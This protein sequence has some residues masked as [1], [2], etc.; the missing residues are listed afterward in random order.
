MTRAPR[1]VSSRPVVRV[2]APSG[3]LAAHSDPLHHG[4][5]RLGASGCEVRWNPQAERRLHRGYLAGTDQQRADELVSALL[6]VGVDIVWCA[7]GGSGLSRIVGQI[8]DRV[9]RETPRVVIGFSDITGLLNTLSSQLGWITFHGPVV[10][11]LGR[12]GSQPFD[13]DHALSILRGQRPKY[14]GR[15]SRGLQGTLM[16][17]NLTVLSGLL[18]TPL[19]PKVE[20]AIWLLEDIG[21]SP[22]KL[23]RTFTHCRNAGLFEGSVGFWLGDFDGV[24]LR[25]LAPRFA[26][27]TELDVGIGALAGHCGPLELMPIGAQIKVG[28]NIFQCLERLVEGGI[29]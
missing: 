26:A 15:C 5:A 12:S 21:E 6:E 11:T 4:L 8:V 22:Y 19:Q 20:G 16:G 28:P 7:R 14:H 10:T 25:E 18:G 23:D 27:D 9:S 2:V 24:C 3:A 1:P 17:G 13:L 29:V